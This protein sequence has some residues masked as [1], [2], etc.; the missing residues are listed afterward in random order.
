MGAWVVWV[1]PLCL[2]LPRY[3]MK[4]CTSPNNHPQTA[5]DSPPQVCDLLVN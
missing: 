1:H 5:A 3:L 2:A 4:M